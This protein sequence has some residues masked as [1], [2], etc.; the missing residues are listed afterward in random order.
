MSSFE[1]I[2]IQKR[3]ALEEQELKRK[4]EIEERNQLK[5][6]ELEKS[7]EI[8]PKIPIIPEIISPAAANNP[9][10]KMTLDGIRG[11]YLIS[12]GKGDKTSNK[13]VLE[14]KLK[15]SLL[16]PSGFG[17]FLENLSKYL[18]SI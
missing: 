3:K 5:I 14:Q 12:S 2:F 8:K 13:V 6:K 9:E 16:N 15:E 10:V 1:E 11:L 17:Q 18:K 4:K 7:K